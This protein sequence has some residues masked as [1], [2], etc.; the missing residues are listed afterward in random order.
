[1]V[2]DRGPGS[3]PDTGGLVPFPDTGG[4]GPFQDTGGLVP[5]PD[6]S[7]LV[8]FPDTGGLVPFPDTGGLVS[9]RRSSMPA[10]PPPPAGSGR[11]Y[12]IITRN[13]LAKLKGHEGE[14]SK[15]R[16][17]FLHTELSPLLVAI[18]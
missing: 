12:N 18:V 13:C 14:I 9:R 5:F 17:L 15:V 7:G 2:G 8:P 1:M 16:V 3:F 11:V 6:T 4:L 10:L